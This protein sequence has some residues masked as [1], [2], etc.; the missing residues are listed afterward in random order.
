MP[1]RPPDPLLLLHR[2]IVA[3]RAAAERALRLAD[4]PPAARLRWRTV[5]ASIA[6]E[7]DISTKIALAEAARAAFAAAA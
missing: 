6:A 7:P 3:A 5:L 1:R 4:D 2:A